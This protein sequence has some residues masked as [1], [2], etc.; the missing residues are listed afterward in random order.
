MNN[1][2]LGTKFEQEFCEFLSQH[3][4]WVHFC[5]PSPNGSQPCDVIAAKNGK[6]YL[7][8]CK[9]SAQKTFR[10][11][12]MEDNQILAFYKWSKCGNSNRFVAVKYNDNVY[13]IPFELLEKKE[14]VVLTDEFLFE[15]QID[16]N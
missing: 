16:Y 1:K 13:M 10:L 11:N 5:T 4:F 2:Q 7:I 15:K 14:K 8:D 6:P 9:T 12:R 3:G